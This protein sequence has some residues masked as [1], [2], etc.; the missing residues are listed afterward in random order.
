M[1]KVN[2]KILPYTSN[3]QPDGSM[4]IYI[5]LT[6]DRKIAYITTPYFIKES[7]WDENRER[8]RGRHLMA[9]D[10]NTYLQNK[11]AEINKKI[12]EADVAGIQLT[13]KSLKE[14]LTSRVDTSNV[15]DFIDAFKD[16]VK[17]KRGGGTLENY[18]K[19]F[20]LLQEYCRGR[21]LSFIDVDV[22]F[23]ARYENWLRDD[24]RLSG[25][26]VHTI[27]NT[28]RMVFNAARKRDVTKNYPF[29]TYEFPKYEEPEKDVLT[30]PELRRWET[31][32]DNAF[33][34]V[35]RE[36]AIWFLFGCYTGLRIGDW[37]QFD[38]KKH[39]TD[40]RIR[41]RAKKNGGWVS[42]PISV[43]L[44]RNL[45]R[46]KRTPLT[47]REATINEKLKVIAKDK[48]VSIDK[49]ITAHTSRHTF[50]VTICL[51]NRV[52]SETAAELMGITLQ[53]FVDNYSQVS[54]EKI[55]RETAE[56]W[57]KLF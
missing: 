54:D 2:V 26:Y 47:L 32:A 49:H 30:F 35:L 14:L 37:R 44:A 34:P 28:F 56:A 1:N 15:F 19:H 27:F 51:G 36:T 9:G 50:A 41:L 21:N 25:N 39:L 42:M 29:A 52:S 5:R 31:F 7:D 53:T 24:K 45:S 17:N 6:I 12:V 46:M 40:D 18:R 20:A 43:P 48:N 11:A 22:K 33:D 13:S 10:I 4:P 38:V 8:I 23:L 16:E 3:R 55:D 57:K